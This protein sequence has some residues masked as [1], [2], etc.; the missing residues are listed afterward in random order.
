MR[1]LFL[2]SRAG[3]PNDGEQ[4]VTVVDHPDSLL[5]LSRQVKATL[6]HPNDCGMFVILLGDEANVP[7]ILGDDGEEVEQ[8]YSDLR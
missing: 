8:L 5:P 6:D 1:T 4:V 2:Y 3:G 7:H